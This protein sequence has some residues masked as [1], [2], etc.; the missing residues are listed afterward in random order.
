MSATLVCPDHGSKMFCWECSEEEET[1]P[2]EEVKVGLDLPTTP[3][4][5]VSLSL[6]RKWELNTPRACRC[7][8]FP[9]H[10]CP[11]CGATIDLTSPDDQHEPDCKLSALIREAEAK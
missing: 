10:R 9:A 6:L 3:G 5:F 7:A 4:A 1:V 8:G 11:D 2:W